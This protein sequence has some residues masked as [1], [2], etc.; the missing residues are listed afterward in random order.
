MLI[1]FNKYQGAGN[2]FIII[3]NLD[4]ELNV[5]KKENIQ[6]LCDRNFGIGADGLILI[7]EAEGYDFEMVYYNSDGLKSTMCGN[8][9][10]CAAAYASKSGIIDKA[11]SFLAADGNHFA[12]IHDDKV[13][14]S[15][16]DVEAPSLIKGYH[17]LDTG[18]P[19]F[20]I[21]VPDCSK[22]DVETKGKEFRSSD[23]FAPGGT[24]VNFMESR[25]TGIYV[26]TYER[27]VEKETLA[28]GTGITAAAISSRWGSSDGDYS[29]QVETKGG[30][31][32]VNFRLN[33]NK[34]VDV[35]LHGP[36]EF[37]FEGKI[38]I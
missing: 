37:V 19:H 3:N 8:G 23:V 10:R 20:V 36:A 17:F 34:A 22:V 31:L 25:E 1:S 13:A 26:R 2:D 11:G 21:P 35:C 6:A 15:L 38:E 24:N 27:G 14:I 9:G 4:G 28:C 29:V 33:N 16:K 12:R 30:S 18:S 5:I 7:N 32:T